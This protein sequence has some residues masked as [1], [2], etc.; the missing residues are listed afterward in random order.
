MHAMT[1]AS[2]G[3]HKGLGHIGCS[4]PAAMLVPLAWWGIYKPS[5][6]E[7]L[8]FL[9]PGKSATRTWQKEWCGDLIGL[10]LHKFYILWAVRQKDQ[11]GL[12]RASGSY[13]PGLQIAQRRSYLYTLGPKV[14][15]VYVH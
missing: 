15:I 12:F 2:G 6:T 9:G 11:L 5:I 1:V 10:Q 8:T 3:F 7:R 4:H 13:I 14:G